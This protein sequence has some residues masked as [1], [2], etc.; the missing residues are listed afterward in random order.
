MGTL[1]WQ[2]SVGIHPRQDLIS[3]LGRARLSQQL[4]FLAE[5]DGPMI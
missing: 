3:R 4:A 2:D 5:K 1:P